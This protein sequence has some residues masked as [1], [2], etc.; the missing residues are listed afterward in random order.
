TCDA[1]WIRPREDSRIQIQG[2]TLFG[3]TPGP[4]VNVLLRHIPILPSR[5][6]YQ[7]VWHITR[8]DA[9]LSSQAG[10]WTLPTKIRLGTTPGDLTNTTYRT[11]AAHRIRI[12]NSELRHWSDSLSRRINN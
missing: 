12:K 11:A 5:C 3:N 6:F 1:A 7:K 9:G 10:E 4:A 8:S 2:I